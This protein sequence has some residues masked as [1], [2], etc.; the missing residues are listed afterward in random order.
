MRHF[1]LLAFHLVVVDAVVGREV[2]GRAV[3]RVGRKTPFSPEELS[4]I[5]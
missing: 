4:G 1:L 2:G 5:F 3:S